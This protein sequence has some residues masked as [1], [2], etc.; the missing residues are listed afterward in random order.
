MRAVVLLVA[1]L[2]ACTTNVVDGRPEGRAA[3]TP[4]GLH[5]GSC[6]DSCG[7]LSPDGCW[8]DDA[9]ADWDDCCPDYEDQCVIVDE[10]PELPPGACVDES[11][12]ADGET[13]VQVQCITT[14]CWAMCQPAC[15][16][17]IRCA[18][19]YHAADADA[20]GCP[21]TCA[22]DEPVCTVSL[23]CIEG[24]TAQDTDGDGCEDACVA[25]QP[26]PAPA[27]DSDDDCPNGY[28]ESFMT[29]MAIGCPPP[30]P[31][32]CVVNDCD[33][34]SELTCRMMA[35]SCPAGQTLAVIDGCW[36]CRDARTCEAI[37]PPP[38]S[39][40]DRCGG[41]A[42]DGCWCDETCA[43]YGD[44]CADAASVCPA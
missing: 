30:P 8:C 33:D 4:Q 34:G 21:D 38:D 22:P 43:W 9:C 27:C 3:A 20:D 29:C 18:A 39:C 44:C 23:L 40:T 37:A 17:A 24:T 11:D 5:G 1:V 7:D 2:S 14:P 10:E 12:C 42:P 28:C 13:C 35:T 6:V 26:P 32:E 25:D 19:G 15:E 16:I 41:Q 31:N 36:Q